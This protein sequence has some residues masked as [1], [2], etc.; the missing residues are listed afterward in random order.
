MTLA[1]SAEARE[2]INHLCL[3]HRR[4]ETGG[5]LLGTRDADRAFVWEATGPGHQANAGQRTLML[6]TSFVLGVITGVQAAG[7]LEVLGRWHK[8]VA[9]DLRTSDDDRRGAEAFRQVCEF[10]FDATNS[11]ELVVGTDDDQPVGYGAYLCT[12]QGIERIAC[13]LSPRQGGRSGSAA[14]FPS[15]PRSAT[16][17]SP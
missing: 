12:V 14:T 17:I 10:A 13:T 8:H 2:Q 16:Q 7:V 9:A 6:D 5:L 3:D 4:R 1:I 11:Y 15:R